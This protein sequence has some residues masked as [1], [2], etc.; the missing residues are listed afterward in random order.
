MKRS[1]VLTLLALVLL[2]GAGPYTAELERVYKLQKNEVLKRVPR[3]Y[4]PERMDWYRAEQKDQAALIPKGPD[5]MVFYWDDQKGLRNEAMGFGY[6]KLPVRRV[7][8]SALKLNSYEIEGPNDLLSLDVAGDWVVR[9][10]ADTAQKLQALAAIIKG[11]HGRTVRFERREVPR[12]VIVASGTWNFQPLKGS[13]NE[14]WV[15]LFSD[16]QDKDEGS[17][18]G[19]GDL[20]QFLQALGDRTGI[21]VVDEVQGDRPTI[22]SWGHHR[23]SR[24]TDLPAGPERQE[25]LMQLLDTVSKQTGLKLQPAMRNTPVWVMTEVQPEA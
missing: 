17:G 24:L 16:R 3:P 2:A 20:A 18:G 13:Y 10:D 1:H 21:R 25:K 22:I 14:K 12:E 19:S 7:L 15:H 8:D 9:K 4:I 11:Q 6:D 23:S 5:Y